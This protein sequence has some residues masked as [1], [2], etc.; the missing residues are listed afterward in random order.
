MR[1][2]AGAVLVLLV[3]AGCAAPP[4]RASDVPEFGQV[5]VLF[6]L[7]QD[8]QVINVRALDR[9]PITG[10]TLI[11]PSGERVPAYSIDQV[12]NPSFTNQMTLGGPQNAVFP[13]GAAPPT[14]AGPSVVPRKTVMIGQIA[15]VGLIRVPD[16][17]VYREVWQQSKVEVHMGT[18]PDDRVEVHPAPQPGDSSAPPDTILSK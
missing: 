1:R 14:L 16:L 7:G 5:K 2:F 10:A 12:N 6:A 13:I 8:V 17:A 4:E 15:S 3:L 11:L 18:A 9:L